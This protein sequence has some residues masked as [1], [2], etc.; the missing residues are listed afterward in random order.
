M[1]SKKDLVRVKGLKIELKRYL[2][3][4]VITKEDLISTGKVEE[5]VV[6]PLLVAL[7]KGRRLSK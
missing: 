1:R 2:K 6:N 3:S 4:G 5:G 7:E